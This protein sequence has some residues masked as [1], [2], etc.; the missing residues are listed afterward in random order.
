MYFNPSYA[1]HFFIPG[2]FPNLPN[3]WCRSAVKYRGQGQSGQAIK[4]FQA[5]QKISFTL[6]FWHKS[7][8]NDDEQLAELSNNSFEWKNVTFWGVQNIS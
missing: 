5:P 2:L 4:L 1:L 3:Q 7:F 8:I 6:H